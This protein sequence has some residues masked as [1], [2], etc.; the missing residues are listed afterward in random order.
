[1]KRLSLIGAAAIVMAACA[2]TQPPQPKAFTCT[3]DIPGMCELQ[4]AG[5]DMRFQQALV[6]Y[7]QQQAEEKA[8]YQR[9]ADEN[10]RFVFGADSNF[11]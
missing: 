7:T 6:A 10:C 3:S 11:C 9:K 4:R 2:T 5:H 8:E 1:M